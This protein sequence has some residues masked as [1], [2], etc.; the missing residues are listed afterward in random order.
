MNSDP[1]P[2]PQDDVTPVSGPFRV[3]VSA[4][5]TGVDLDVSHYL[6]HVLLCIAEAVAE[7]PA[8][9]VERF[10]E[11]ADAARIA[12]APGTDQVRAA[13]AAERDE[14]TEDMV[15][16]FAGRGLV[17]VYGQQV[18]RLTERLWHLIRPRSIPAQQDAENRGGAAA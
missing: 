8:A 9:M 18:V 2:A 16:R 6:E 14:I 5:P 7:D 1:T 15:E 13:A 3:S 10:T 4:H 12:T 17:P 11:L